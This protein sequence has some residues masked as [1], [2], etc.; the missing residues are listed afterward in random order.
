MTGLSTRVRGWRFVSVAITSTSAIIT[1]SYL[2][3]LAS[4]WDALGQDTVGQANVTAAAVAM[5]VLAADALVPVPSSLVMVAVGSAFPIPLALVI[6]FT[7]R[8]AMSLICYLGG[9]LSCSAAAKVASVEER[10]AARRLLEH[11]GGYAILLTRP[12]PV[13]SESVLL[14]AGLSRMPFRSVV[15]AATLASAAEGSAYVL[16][17]HLAS[18]FY[19]A[20]AL[21]LVLIILSCAAAWARIRGNRS[22]DSP[23]GLISVAPATLTVRL[24]ED[25][26][27]HRL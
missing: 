16:I 15:L 8:T 20:A 22:Q 24:R 10:L 5:L 12:I 7:G 27:R 21:W 14:V 18:E 26:P 25:C 23:A 13:L 11:H 17:G 6:A 19:A 3:A 9:R 4:G 1:A 2:V